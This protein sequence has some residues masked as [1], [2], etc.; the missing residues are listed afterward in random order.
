MQLDGKIYKKEFR[1]RITELSTRRKNIERYLL[2]R[3]EMNPQFATKVA[4]ILEK[5]SLEDNLLNSGMYDSVI[6]TVVQQLTQ[7]K[8]SSFSEAK[9]I[10]KKER[11]EHLY[12]KQ[13]TDSQSQNNLPKQ[14]TTPLSEEQKKEPK[15]DKQQYIEQ[16]QE[17]WEE[18]EQK[19]AD[20]ISR[21]SI[22]R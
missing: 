19:Y 13:T 17:A 2:T 5:T 18:L 6:E 20:M 8:S 4:D 22:R 7:R 9:H 12:S 14:N 15:T 10:R 11:D 1:E 16:L 3:Y 21:H